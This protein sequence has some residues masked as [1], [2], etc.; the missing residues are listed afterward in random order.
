MFCED[1]LDFYYLVK[2]PRRLVAMNSVGPPLD[3]EA[4]WRSGAS[5]GADRL[6]ALAGRRR[7][8]LLLTPRMGDQK[9]AEISQAVHQGLLTDAG[10]WRE[11]E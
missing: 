6:A 2:W 11:H 9:A 8:L 10:R 1:A 7:S 3:P 4:V 5:H